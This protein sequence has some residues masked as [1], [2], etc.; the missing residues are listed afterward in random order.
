MKS[1]VWV[2]DHDTGYRHIK[3]DL[4][5]RYG[6]EKV[7][8]IWEKAG[9]NWEELCARYAHLPEKT[10]RHTDG[11]MFRMAVVYMALKE[12]YP[13]IA[14]ETLGTGTEREGRRIAKMLSCALYIPGMDYVFLRIFAKMLDSSF[15]EDAGFRSTKH[16]ISK[17]EVCFDINQCPY[18]QVLTEIGCPEIIHFSCEIDEWIYGNLPGL[19]F[20]RSGT[21]DTGADKCDFC[22]KRARK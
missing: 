19:E 10:K 7:H 11:Q 9:S 6:K 17:D 13:E 3:K 20:S 12:A 5:K 21:L 14:L 18:C 2:L 8:Q 1:G 4:I 15:N 22:L 16:C